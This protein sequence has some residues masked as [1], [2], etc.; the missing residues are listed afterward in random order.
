MDIREC[1]K[2]GNEF[3]K[4]AMKIK[5]L[6]CED[7]V[8]KARMNRY[9]SKQKLDPDYMER[10]KLRNKT[11]RESLTPE[12]KQQQA[13]ERKNRYDNDKALFSERKRLSREKHPDTNSAYY[14]HWN[15]THKEYLKEY[16]KRNWDKQ[17]FYASKR[18]AKKLQA[19]PKWLTPEELD[20][21]RLIYG[22]CKRISID[23]G[24]VH[25]VDHIYPLQGKDSCGLHVPWNLQVITKTDNLKK[26]NKLILPCSYE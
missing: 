5:S 2:C 7:C 20:S 9:H 23:T 22:E 21:I 14:K 4:D 18:R 8:K 16:R 24:I 10:N 1:K 17:L 19:M 13:I 25:N 6:C 12:I 26:G 11:H 3:D 15:A